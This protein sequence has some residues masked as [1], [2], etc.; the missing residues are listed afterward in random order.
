M[1]I[2]SSYKFKKYYNII[3]IIGNGAYGTVFNGREIKTNELR[4][5]KVIQLD[6]LKGSILAYGDEY[7]DPDKK[8]K[9]CIEGFIK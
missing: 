4:A 3:D 6:D 2:G 7:E 9:E 8:L 5:I 1:G